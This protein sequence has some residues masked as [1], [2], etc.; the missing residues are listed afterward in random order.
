MAG[1]HFPLK[2]LSLPKN[3]APSPPIT[4][5]PISLIKIDCTRNGDLSYNNEE[6]PGKIYNKLNYDKLIHT[7][8]SDKTLL[9]HKALIL[10]TTLT[11]KNN[12]PLKTKS[13]EFIC[14][15]EISIID[16]ETFIKAMQ[17]LGFSS[18]NSNTIHLIRIHTN[19][20]DEKILSYRFQSI[21]QKKNKTQNKTQK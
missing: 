11:R 6:F 15:N 7:D 9:I 20:P 5:N 13:L 2:S 12:T 1:E 8:F 3:Y 17:T 16:L 18:N 10:H 21:T 14:T 19:E 4:H